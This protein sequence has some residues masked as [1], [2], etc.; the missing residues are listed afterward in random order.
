M[1]S[2]VLPCVRKGNGPSFFSLLEL[3][4]Y[5]RSIC[6]CQYLRVI[7]MKTFVKAI[8]L[9]LAIAAKGKSAHVCGLP[10]GYLLV[11]QPASAI[12]AAAVH[13]VRC[14]GRHLSHGRG[15]V[16]RAYLTCPSFLF[17][18]HAEQEAPSTSTQPTASRPLPQWRPCPPPWRA[19]SSVGP[20]A[21]QRRG[22]QTEGRRGRPVGCVSNLELSQFPAFCV[23]G[24]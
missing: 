11:E 20:L 18:H 9:A 2:F 23:A 19:R 12:G 10:L 6:H 22:L 16:N 5:G 15:R 7:T 24:H 3:I 8:L 14:A 17:I 4:K 21:G 1:S 13:A